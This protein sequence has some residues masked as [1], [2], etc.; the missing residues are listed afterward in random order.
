[1]TVT[2]QCVT[3]GWSDSLKQSRQTNSS[4]YGR[5]KFEPV[6]AAQVPAGRKGAPMNLIVGLGNP[7]AEYVGTRHNVG[8]EVI[9][10]LARRHNISVQK[11]TLQSVIGDGVIGGERV[12]LMRPMTKKKR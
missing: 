7:G 4:L 10:R 2:E 5:H 1:M 9:E 6:W 3:Y 8:F 11:R 12:I